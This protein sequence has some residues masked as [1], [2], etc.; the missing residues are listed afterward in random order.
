MDYI[1][2]EV[3]GET[4]A[5]DINAFNALFKKDFLPLKDRHLKD[6]Y[7]WLVHDG[8]KLV[9][10]AGMVPFVPF[11]CVGYWKRVAVLPAYRGKG[12]PQRLM[13]ASFERARASTD[14]THIISECSAD[15]VS[16]AN[17]LIAGGYKL[18]ETERPWA[19]DTLFWVKSLV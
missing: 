12:I 18:C 11:P 2:T 1:L 6:G 8:V 9:G 14:W 5:A 10:F 7:W 16:S 17:R 13:Q 19:K 4:H 15:N 3:S